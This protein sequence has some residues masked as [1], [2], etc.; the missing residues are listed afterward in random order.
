MVNR[1]NGCDMIDLNLKIKLLDISGNEIVLKII[2]SY[3]A[4]RGE[5]NLLFVSKNSKMILL[6]SVFHCQ[7]SSCF[8]RHTTSLLLTPKMEI[9]NEDLK[10]VKKIEVTID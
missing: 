5:L 8:A 4:S 9:P 2:N 7:G 10:K 6:D 3:D 1:L